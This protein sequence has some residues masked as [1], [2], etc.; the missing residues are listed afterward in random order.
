MRE[1]IYRTRRYCEHRIGTAREEDALSLCRQAKFLWIGIERASAGVVDAEFG[2][3]IA[4]EHA[5]L[6]GIVW[7]A[8]DN[9]LCILSVG[10]YRDYLDGRARDDSCDLH[11]VRDYIENSRRGHT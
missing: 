11:A 8:I 9:L 3:V 1:R 6:N 7:R 10:N 2:L 5:F 4:I